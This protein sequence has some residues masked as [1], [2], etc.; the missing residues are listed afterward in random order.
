MKENIGKMEDDKK[1]VFP[2][3]HLWFF[4]LFLAEWHLW[5]NYI[6]NKFKNAIQCLILEY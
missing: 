2:E 5:Y 4:L 6:Y 1:Q 3:L